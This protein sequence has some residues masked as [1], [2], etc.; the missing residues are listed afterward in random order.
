MTAHCGMGPP[1]RRQHTTYTRPTDINNCGQIVGEYDTEP[2][3][4]SCFELSPTGRRLEASTTGSGRRTD[5]IGGTLRN[6][7]T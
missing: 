6:R 2:S 4:A 3:R 7:G 5:P 1:R